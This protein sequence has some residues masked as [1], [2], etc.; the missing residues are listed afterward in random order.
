MKNKICHKCKV[1]KNI[2]EFYIRKERKNIPYTVCKECYKL[3]PRKKR[4]KLSNEELCKIRSE[5][6][7]KYL[8]D[9]PDKHPWKSNA[10]FKSVPCENF[11]AILDELNIKYLPEHTPSNERAFAIDVSLPQYKIGIEVN[12][13][14]HY[15]KDGSL[16]SYY[17]ERHDFLTNLGFEIHELH[18]SLFFDR[19]KMIQLINSIIANKPLFDFNYEEYLQ[20]KLNKI[21]RNEKNKVCKCGETIYKASK[22]CLNCK[23]IKQRKVLVR[24]ELD[25]LL[26]DVKELGYVGTGKKYNVSDNAIKKWIKI[27][28]KSVKQE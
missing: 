16:A 6:M 7:K 4:N 17:Q 24:P 13:N 26:K 18:F 14:Q 21:K 28:Q 12:G 25:T 9:N 23:N 20:N 27:Y 2:E 1:S 15:N 11:K 10:K 5:A 19:E 22:M 8:R 3:K